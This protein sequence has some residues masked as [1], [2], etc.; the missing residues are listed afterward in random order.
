[1]PSLVQIGAHP[2][3]FA[4]FIVCIELRGSDKLAELTKGKLSLV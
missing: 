3:Y 4:L 1:M 2:Q